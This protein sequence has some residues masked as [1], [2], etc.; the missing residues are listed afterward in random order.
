MLTRRQNLHRVEMALSSEFVQ[1][2]SHLELSILSNEGFSKTCA[3]VHM[4]SLVKSQ[5]W[6]KVHTIWQMLG[7][8]SQPKSGTYGL[9]GQKSIL[10][11]V[12]VVAVAMLVVDV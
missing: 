3:C 7:S 5:P 9:L 1:K 11:V 10:S 2:L 12:V 4:A 8:G 6:E